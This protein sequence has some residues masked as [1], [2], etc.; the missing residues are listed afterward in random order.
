MSASTDAATVIQPVDLA[1]ERAALGPQVEEAV[2]R[3]L[4]SGQYVLGPEVEAFEG[5]FAELCRVPHAFGVSSGEGQA[6]TIYV[7]ARR[8]F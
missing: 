6:A 2:L 7:G 1:A 5:R 8:I 3:V 4:R